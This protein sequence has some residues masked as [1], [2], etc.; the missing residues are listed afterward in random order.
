MLKDFFVH[1]YSCRTFALI[2]PKKFPLPGKSL[3]ESENVINVILLNSFF[4]CLLLS[5]SLA[6]VCAQANE[7]EL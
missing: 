5:S 3:E 7:H 6:I 4:C 1:V 2:W